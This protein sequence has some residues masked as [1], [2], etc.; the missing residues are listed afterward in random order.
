MS[1]IQSATNTAKDTQLALQALPWAQKPS[2]MFLNNENEALSQIETPCAADAPLHMT[3]A[4]G[5]QKILVANCKTEP[6]PE[7]FFA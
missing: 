5:G 4:N 1:K 2:Q 3:T 7:L 6:D